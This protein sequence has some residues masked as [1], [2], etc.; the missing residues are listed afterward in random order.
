MAILQVNFL[1]QALFRTVPS[2]V[3]LPSLRDRGRASRPQPGLPGLFREAGLDLTYE[4]GP[5]N[6]NWEF[7]DKY[8]RHVLDW[9]PLD[10]A[11]AGLSSGNV[12]KE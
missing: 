7:W 2:S 8:I 10:E 6:H 12:V 5:G 4:E 1:S 11:K 9:L 3:P